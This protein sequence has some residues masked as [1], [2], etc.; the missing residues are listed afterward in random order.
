MLK[1]TILGPGVPAACQS[2]GKNFRITYPA[3]L[4]AAFPGAAVMV[5]A[6]FFHSKA[7]MYGISLVG[8]VLMIGLHLLWVPLVKEQ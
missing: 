4:K 1:K 6:L 3:W 2:C 8:L 7:L 5:A